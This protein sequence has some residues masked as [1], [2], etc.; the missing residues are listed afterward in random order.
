[1]T[2]EKIFRTL[3]RVVGLE[4]REARR[5]LCEGKSVTI[6]FH[7]GNHTF[8]VERFGR[9]AVVKRRDISLLVP[10]VPWSD[11]DERYTNLISQWPLEIDEVL[12]Q[13]YSDRFDPNYF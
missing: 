1:M 10:F 4:G 8:T 9:Y 2:N 3:S 12:L 11:I 6:T 5:Y 7:S 13:Q